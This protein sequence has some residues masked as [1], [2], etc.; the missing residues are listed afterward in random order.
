MTRSTGILIAAAAAMWAVTGHAWA[1]DYPSQPITIIV[2]GAAG[3][4]GD[5]VGRLLAE[6]L[7]EELNQPVVV[8][9]RPGS[10]GNLAASYVSRSDADGYTILLAYSGSHVAN[11]S[12]FP[13]LGWD[14]VESFEPVALA[15][16]APHVI[17]VREGLEV[18]TLSDL[19]EYARANPGSLNY[20]SS[21]I[22]SI[23]HI[24]TEQLARLADV[25]MVHVPYGGAGP[26][27]NDMLGG[28]VD[29]IV[30]TPPAVVG[31]VE[32]GSVK[33]LAIAS[34][35]RHPMLPDIPTTAEAGFEGFELEAWFG[36]YAP[37]GT[38]QE[39]IETLAAAAEAVIGS[40]DFQER[41]AQAGTQA[42]FM[43]P[44]E[45]ADFTRTEISYWA[46][47]I[48]EVGIEVE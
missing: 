16:K 7:T 13:D 33:A 48:D 19:I 26:A 45:L 32:A 30:T 27:M 42:V 10:H 11:P 15:V 21:G 5:F 17:V 47:V 1:Q 38:P 25:E 36:L 23:Q 44:E 43:G 12:L 35:E 34:G 28:H 40:D 8:E 39:A 46:E 14:P 2:P 41:A 37:A 18:E 22:G 9:N 29:L 24:G 3:G 4:G 20:A 6:K 31:H